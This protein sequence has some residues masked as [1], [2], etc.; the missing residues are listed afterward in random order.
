[1]KKC[2]P[3]F[4]QQLDNELED[5]EIGDNQYKASVDEC[6]KAFLQFWNV[7]IGATT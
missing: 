4:C 1:M 5:E 7:V 2:K 6:W 3:I